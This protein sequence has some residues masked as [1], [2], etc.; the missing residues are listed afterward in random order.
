MTSIDSRFGFSAED[1]SA[2]LS[3]NVSNE[4]QQLPA[5]QFIP[6][7]KIE[8]NLPANRFNPTHGPISNIDDGN[9]N[10]N[11]DGGNASDDNNEGGN[12][13]DDNS[14]DSDDNSNG[15][16]DNADFRYTET[17]Y[18]KDDIGNTKVII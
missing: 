16:G 8:Q 18:T 6:V 17:Y 1:T 5:S 13:S 12:N 9:N 2:I 3:R 4:G 7:P 11:N 14:N 15:G 10:N